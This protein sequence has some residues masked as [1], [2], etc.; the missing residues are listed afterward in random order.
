MQSRFSLLNS[1]TTLCHGASRIRYTRRIFAKIIRLANA[2]LFARIAAWKEAAHFSLFRLQYIIPCRG[3]R[4][5]EIPR[6]K[7]RGIIAWMR[8]KL[9]GIAPSRQSPRSCKHDFGS[10]LAGIKSPA[11]RTLV[12]EHGCVSSHFLHA[13]CAV[14]LVSCFIPRFGASIQMFFAS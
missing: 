1:F 4:Q 5:S 14:A 8:S 11:C 7:L 13:P 12:S 3:A 9:R 10:L 6:S 2:S